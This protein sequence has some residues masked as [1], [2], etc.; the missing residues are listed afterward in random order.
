MMCDVCDMRDLW[1]S[2]ATKIAAG[3]MVVRELV[4]ELLGECV[5]ELVGELLSD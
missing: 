2:P 3:R 4:R 5:R 1:R